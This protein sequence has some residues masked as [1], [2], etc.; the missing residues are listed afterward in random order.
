ML[1]VSSLVIFSL[2]CR[3]G[4]LCSLQENLNVVVLAYLGRRSGLV[5]DTS[6]ISFLFRY[7][8]IFLYNLS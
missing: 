7:R 3:H 8:R 1:S 2:F 4:G 5:N 6:F